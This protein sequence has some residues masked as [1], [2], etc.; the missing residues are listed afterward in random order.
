MIIFFIFALALNSPINV[1]KQSS[2][3]VLKK[4]VFWKYP[5]NLQENTHAEAQCNFIEIALRHGCFR[6]SLLH[7][8]RAP[9]L[10]NTSGG[11]LLN[12]GKENKK[13]LRTWG[14]GTDKSLRFVRDCSTKMTRKQQTLFE[15]NTW[16]N[17]EFLLFFLR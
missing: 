16:Q 8:F 6:V 15:I 13:S 12:V 2:R 9:F 14:K 1:Q 3:D 7:I 5:A 10:K 17:L 4:K 11:L